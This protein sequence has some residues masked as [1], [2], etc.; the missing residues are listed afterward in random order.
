MPTGH[1]VGG[2]VRFGPFEFDPR[3]L[4]LRRS[5]RPIRLAPQPAH[6]LGTLLARPGEMVT[7]E[8][9]RQELWSHDTFVDFEAGLNYC[10]GRLR[11]VL[12]DDARKPTFI[13]TLPRRGYR[14]IAPVERL[15]AAQRTLAVLPFDNIGG[16]STQDFVA[17]GVADGLITELGKIRGL[18]VISRQ[19][20]L[21]FKGSTLRM[22]EIAQRLHADTVLEGSVLQRGDRLRI[23]AQLIEVQPER[24][25]WA[26]SYE[27]NPQDFMDVLVRVARAVAAAIR[28][29]LGPEDDARLRSADRE[30]VPSY[31]PDS[32]VAFLKA[33]FHLG[34]WSRAE[35]QQALALFHEAIALDPTHAPAHAA[36]ASC[37]SLI[38]YNGQAPW[39]V[40]YPQ[41]KVMA[42]RAVQLDASSSAAQSSLG[43]VKLVY[44]WDFPAAEACF[45]RAVEVNPSNEWALLTRA[46]FQLWI[47]DDQQSALEAVDVAL[48]IDP[49]SPFTNSMAAWLKLM[50]FRYDET[51][52]QAERTLRMYKDAHQAL[53]ALAWARVAAGD[54]QDGLALFE[55]A[56]AASPDEMTLGFLGH[57][58]ALAGRRGEARRMLDR[59]IGTDPAGHA[60]VKSIVGVLAGLG[61]FDRAFEWIDRGIAERDGGL[62]SSRVSPPFVPLF[63]DPRFEAVMRRIGLPPWREGPPRPL[64]PAG[65]RGQ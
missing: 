4:D 61:D 26:E 53:T 46:L 41:A 56:A 16:D 17:D 30:M 62:L 55:Q 1:P 29:V 33:R 15:G 28:V 45:R 36:L 18:R 9:L 13:E 43:F 64:S 47:Q 57:A 2:Q 32:Q 27:G 8:E 49:V 6:V 10:L 14:F 39:R 24:H 31:R 60:C 21:G 20:V 7:R 65:R 48:A 58:Y 3:S 25:L 54:V 40:V 23:T 42:E 59:L 35:F 22:A 44:D 19:S 11:A 52:A 63:A 37:L 38:G 12:G 34:K 51:A 5:G 50:A